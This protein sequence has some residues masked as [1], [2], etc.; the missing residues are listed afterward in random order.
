MKAV[1]LHHHSGTPIFEQHEDPTPDQGRSLVR[2][3][4]APIVPLDLLCASGTSY[5]GPPALP[6]VPGV[7]GVG[8]L[9]DSPVLAEGTRVWFATSAGM[10]P[11]DG[12]MAER[13][14]VAGDDLVV[15][16]APLGDAEVAA[17]GTSGVAAW[18]SLT[19]RAGL[20]E[21]ENVI[22]LGAS[23]MVGRVAVAS[24]RALG[25]GRVVAV[26]RSSTAQEALT[27]AGADVVVATGD[28]VDPGELTGRLQEAVGGLA[29][30][31]IDPVFGPTATAAAAALGP[32]GR[33]VNIGGTAGDSAAFSSAV[34]R[35]RTIGILGYTNN[36]LTPEQR[37]DAL[38]SVL[39]VVAGRPNLLSSRRFPAARCD[40]GW[41][42]AA[43][44]GS[45][46]VLEF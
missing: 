2:V 40:E 31:V 36:A 13:C 1:V 34:L 38:R 4:A 14:A 15:I 19:W 3:S 39:D 18:M 43:G 24:A 5:F 8:T 45:R 30:V 28:S 44:G 29:H 17:V 9:L 33:L 37:A 26:C 32:G 12:S 27:E 46:V 10:A 35:G 11:G 7:Q 25:A 16:T 23:G 21:G 6:Y 22:V 20:R 42:A 41:T